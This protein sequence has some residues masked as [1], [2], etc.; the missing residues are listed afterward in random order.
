M[1]TSTL[2]NI[3]AA[4]S[5]R[6]PY[7]RHTDRLYVE[8]VNFW[9]DVFPGDL[10]ERLSRAPPDTVC[11][12]SVEA[13]EL[14]AA[15]DPALV[16]RLRTTQFNRQPRP[17]LNL[18]PRVGRFYPLN[19]LQGLDGFFSQDR[20][21]FRVLDLDAEA[22]TVDINHPLA[23]H[24]GTVEARVVE[25]LETKQE[26]GGR[27][28]DI[29]QALCERGPGMQG[30]PAHGETDFFD[31]AGFVRLDPRDDA[32]FYREARLVQHLDTRAR[33]Q[34]SAIYG[35]FLE[36]GQRVLDLMSSWVSHLPD[37]PSGLAVTGLGLNAE[38][39]AQNPRLTERIVHD[40]NAEPVLPLP[41][42][43]FDL[44]VCT[45][46]AEYLVRPIEV[47]T[48]VA[49]TLSPGAPFVVTFSE[50]WFPTKV[51][52]VWTE[53]HP[54]E[55]IGL[56]VDCLRRAGFTDIATESIRGWPRPPED[57]YADQQAFADPMYAV[58]GHAPA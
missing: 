55:R 30:A 44:A 45:A 57:P 17:G 23:G 11:R 22:L 9:R 6:S 33:Q 52:Q 35:R 56:V 41:P 18:T 15:R 26:H 28:N 4:V 21:P 8:R 42:S 7:A 34:I 47:F 12:Q 16:R 58:W 39:L 20:R 5:W 13:G 2:G 43:S 14:V 54:F 25:L 24:P 38:E 48:A 53:L 36:P 3:E 27:C 32:Q 46:S 50:R 49:G 31:P 51:V 19:L 40:L 37:A 10:A 1:D 29:G